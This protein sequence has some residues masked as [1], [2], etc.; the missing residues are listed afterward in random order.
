VSEIDKKIQAMYSR[1][2]TYEAPMKEMLLQICEQIGYGRVLQIVS[3]A[4]VA[5]DPIGAKLVGTCKGLTVPCD[6]DD[7][8]HCEWCC[9]SGWLTE[10]VSELKG[11]D[12]AKR[13][14]ALEAE[15]KRMQGDGK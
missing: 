13:V 9:G 8:P 5:K 4:W 3:Q 1:L 6:C 12:L 2:D 7:K 15:M 11:G 10:H 14:Q